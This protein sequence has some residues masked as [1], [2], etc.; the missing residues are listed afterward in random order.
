MKSANI[1]TAH[2]VVTNPE[3]FHNRPNILAAAWEILME[4]RGKQVNLAR[5]GPPAHLVET[6]A[7]STEA[8]ATRIIARVREIA[9]A[10][11]YQRGP[12]GGDAA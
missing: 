9:D 10:K 2:A 3:R 11:G 12:Y 7:D 5:I 6:T 8:R 4:Q 1:S